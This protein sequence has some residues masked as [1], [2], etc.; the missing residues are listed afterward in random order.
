VA[1]LERILARV[2]DHPLATHL[3]IH[4]VEASPHPVK[5]L[6]AA[7]ALRARVPGSG[8]LVHMPSHIDIR[9]GRY[10]EAIVAN[11][12]AIEV[13]R[14]WPAGGFY[15]LYRAHNFHFLAYAAMF[16]GQRATALGAADG[17][18]RE[19]PVEA[20]RAMPDFLDG[21][22][23]VPTHVRVRF[24]LWD[25]LLAAA[26]PPADLAV[27]R[28]MWRYGRT[29]AFAALGRV[30]E[31]EKE[32]A[33]FREARA[34]VPESRFIGNNP[35][36]VVLDLGLRVAEGEVLYRRGDHDRAFALFAEAAE[37]DDALRYDEPWG[38]MMPVRHALGALLAE[39]GRLADAEAV[40]RADLALHPENGWALRGLAECLERTG[41]ADEAAKVDERFRVVWARADVAIES[42]CYCRQGA[43]P[44]K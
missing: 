33:L 4:A 36:A 24:G 10:R 40:Y 41:R 35:A 21:F 29:V 44:G 12:R 26:P 13:D 28:A 42:S 39:Q 27:T 25:E 18:V 15:T 14:T 2:P 38:W 7:D 34:A 1:L 6:A 17:L 22:H 9:L 43:R 19:V 37:Q 8:H 5:A 20:V 3:Y 23:A 31:A 30:D 11:Q 16:D 32:L